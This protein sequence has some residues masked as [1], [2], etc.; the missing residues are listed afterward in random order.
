MTVSDENMLSRQRR[1]LRENGGHS[2]GV[3]VFILDRITSLKVLFND[4]LVEQ[5]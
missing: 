5:N 3:C 1:A 4:D 2:E